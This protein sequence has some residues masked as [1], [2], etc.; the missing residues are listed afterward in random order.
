MKTFK[1]KFFFI[2]ITL[3]ITSFI[4][5]PLKKF[6]PKIYD[7]FTFFNE[8]D[9]LE[10][11]LKEL[12]NTVDYFVIV[13]N[14]LTYSGNPKPLYFL[15]NKHKFSKY[16]DKI[17][18]IISPKIQQ[19]ENAWI[20]EFAQRNAILLGLKK[21]RRKD[22][23]IISDLDEIISASIIPQLKKIFTEKNKK[24]RRSNKY[25]KME[26][27]HY[28]YY[29]NRLYEDSWK[30]AMATTYNKVKERTPQRLRE[31]HYDDWLVIKN[32]GW[33]FSFLGNLE[34]IYYK[35]ESY[36][37]QECNNEK[38][39]NSNYISNKIKECTLVPID[40]SFPKA[41]VNNLEYYETLGHIDKKEY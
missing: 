20:R 9:L 36:A 11:R 41:I 28:R 5:V 27:K 35:I 10:I 2:F 29:L 18:H 40:N 21:A 39:K 26:Q 34:K 7:C 30:R 25:V 6:K 17:I 13:E 38:F 8:L 12:Y 16:S 32:G 24:K 19:A 33:H 31:N 23:I 15:E 3:S 4:F 14:P 1:K 37:H 22:I